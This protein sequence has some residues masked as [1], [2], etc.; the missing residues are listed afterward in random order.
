ME[1]V[2][3]SGEAVQDIKQILKDQNITKNHLRIHGKIG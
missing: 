1:L 2:K 3:I